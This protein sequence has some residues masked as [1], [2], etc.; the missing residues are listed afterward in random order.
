[1]DELD[2]GLRLGHELNAGIDEL[3]IETVEVETWASGFIMDELDELGIGMFG[4]LKITIVSTSF[5]F[6][7]SDLV[8]VRLRDGR[9][10]TRTIQIDVYRSWLRN[11]YWLCVME[12]STRK[13]LSSGY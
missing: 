11:K 10:G 6:M 1:M 3:D 9:L 2:I 8:P 13:H 4:D 7:R 5:G 12:I